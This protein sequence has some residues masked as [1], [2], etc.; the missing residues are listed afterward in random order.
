MP[1]PLTQSVAAAIPNNSPVDK[2]ELRALFNDLLSGVNSIEASGTIFLTNIAGSANAITADIPTGRGRTAIA[3][4]MPVALRATGQNTGPVTL[5][6]GGLT[7]PIV[8][9]A[10]RALTGGEFTMNMPLLLRL[11]GNAPGTEWRIMSALVHPADM[12]QAISEQGARLSDLVDST[13]DGVLP[14]M[15]QIGDFTPLIVGGGG[16]TLLAVDNDGFPVLPFQ[17]GLSYGDPTVEAFTGLDRAGRRLFGFDDM[18]NPSYEPEGVLNY[19]SSDDD[20]DFAFVDNAGRPVLRWSNGSLVDAGGGVDLSGLP[21]TEKEGWLASLA[22]NDKGTIRRVPSLYLTDPLYNDTSH[23]IFPNGADIYPY[24]DAL[25]AA[26]PDYITRT[27]IGATVE[28]VPIWQYTFAAPPVSRDGWSLADTER[29]KIVMVSGIHGGERQAVV[30]QLLFFRNLCHHWAALPGYARLRFGATFIAIPMV[31]PWGMD[32]PAR[33]NSNGVDINRNFP[34]DWN[35]AP[36]VQNG[37]SWR[38]PAP[39]SEPETQALIGALNTH[40]DAIA[41][42]D[43]HNGGLEQAE[44]WFGTRRRAELAL[45]QSVMPDLT[46]YMRGTINPAFPEQGT[47][48]HLSAN[49]PGTFARYTQDV[50]GL[51]GIL[52]EQTANPNHAQM[53]GSHRSQRRLGEQAFIA[54]CT[55]LLDRHDRRRMELE[56]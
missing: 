21:T 41:V 28:N 24:Y 55:A 35:D 48:V 9:G 19:G 16:E 49:G 10:G 34:A 53:D 15:P 38:G 42:F 54:I 1:I 7:L 56:N 22:W 40:S 27:Q 32:A 23:Q 45:I 37:F 8:D 4:G 31:N 12:Q 14:G 36:D 2:L 3:V 30:R 26:F 52:F 6:V 11:S 51:P 18:G 29:P 46:S 43:N 33:V 25:V 20:W 50:A 17:A 13:I 5:A 47:M 44:L 39:G